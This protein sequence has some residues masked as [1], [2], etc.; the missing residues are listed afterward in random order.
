MRLIRILKVSS[1][2]VVVSIIIVLVLEFT[3]R[4]L[5]F[6]YSTPHIMYDKNC[7]WRMA[8]KQKMYDRDEYGNDII[9]TVNSLGARGKNF[10]VKKTS[11]QKRIICLGDSFT[12]GWGVDDT[13]TYP[14][15]LQNSIDEDFSNFRV[16]NFGCNGHTILHEVK[17]LEK[18]GLELK[19]DY[20]IVATSL[21]TDFVD[22]DELEYRLGY[23]PAPGYNLI[24]TCIRK[25]AIG[26]ILLKYWN[27]K[28]VK[29]I[30]FERNQAQKEKKQVQEEKRKREYKSFNIY[31]DKLD[32]LVEIGL[33]NNFKII[34]VI[35]PWR[36]MDLSEVK[37]MGSD[38]SSWGSGL[39]Y[40]EFLKNRY[41]DSI[42]FIELMSHFKSK[43][44]FLS[45]WHLN[46]KGNEL[47][48]EIIH[49]NIKHLLKAAP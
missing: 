48:A 14:A 38:Q 27:S 2:I 15:H 49:K 19:P 36:A 35:M 28:K 4:F 29:T 3:L 1:Y 12:Y 16:I 44:L 11:G 46:T 47:A 23:M 21:H 34:Y 40:Y 8:P 10:P 13:S 6:A 24:K 7:Y 18:Y 45:D 9:F 22:I 33:R 31:I 25:T 20:V 32:E 42:V 5:G 41:G 37:I 39:Q 26:N 17:L 43:D 30:L